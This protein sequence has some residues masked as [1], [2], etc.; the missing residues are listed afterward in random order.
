MMDLTLQL[1]FTAAKIHKDDETNKKKAENFAPY[2]CI[3]SKTGLLSIPFCS[4]FVTTS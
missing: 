1:L 4:L 3:I 2:V